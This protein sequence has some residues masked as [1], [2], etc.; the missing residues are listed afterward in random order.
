MEH[1]SEKHR[2]NGPPPSPHEARKVLFQRGL[3][4]GWL[5]RSEIDAALPEAALSPSERWL[6]FYSLR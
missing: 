1:G 2:K 3:R 4:R 6:L 5:S